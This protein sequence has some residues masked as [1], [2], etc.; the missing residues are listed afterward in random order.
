MF[1]SAYLASI[2]F[3]LG[4]FYLICLI[5]SILF[6]VFPVFI[7]LLTYTVV[8]KFFSAIYH[9]PF[10]VCVKAI[11]VFSF[12]WLCWRAAVEFY[13]WS[14]RLFCNLYSW[15]FKILLL[16]HLFSH[17]SSF[18]HGVCWVPCLRF[19]CKDR[20]NVSPYICQMEGFTMRWCIAMMKHRIRYCHH[21]V[22]WWWAGLRSFSV[23][24]IFQTS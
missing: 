19:V 13:L 18:F 14:P 17:A 3:G 6:S 24:C 22:L 15:L 7:F 1:Q 21:H 2:L 8:Y 10:L 12:M 9:F 11:S 23:R 16:S 5:L 4:L 20:K